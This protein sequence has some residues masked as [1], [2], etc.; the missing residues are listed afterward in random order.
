VTQTLCQ[1][2]DQTDNIIAMG[3][4][5]KTF[6]CILLVLAV[7]IVYGRACGFGFIDCDD[8]NYVGYVSAQPAGF[9][10]DNLRWAA[11]TFTFS[12]WH[13]LTWISYLLDRSWFNDNPGIMHAENI[14]LHAANSALLFLVLE[15][16]T[17]KSWRSAMV[18]ALFA[19]H[20]MHVESVVWIAERKDVLSMFFLLMSWLIYVEY[21]RRPSVL[22][23]L[24]LTTSFALSLASKAMGVTFPILLLL[25]DVWPLGRL[26][27]RS[28]KEWSRAIL[29]KVPLLLLSLIVSILTVLA[30]RAGRSLSTL[31]SIP[32]GPRLANAALGCAVYVAKLIV[33]VDL[34]VFYPM[35]F[36]FPPMA[37]GSAILLLALITAG[38]MRIGK[39]KSYLVIGWFWFLVSLLPMI[40]LVQV[41]QQ[42]IADRYSYLPSIGIS[43]A[44][45]WGL[46]DLFGTGALGKGILTAAGAGVL[47]V[48][49]LLTWRQVGYWTDAQTLFSH[50][51]AVTDQ[52]WFAYCH[53]GNAFAK[54]GDYSAATEEYL[55]TIEFNPNYA[56]AYCN[57]GNCIYMV[58]PARAIP[59][60]LKTIELEPEDSKG[61]I[62]LANA[63]YALGRMND[64]AD[65]YRK[66]L[67]R[68]PGS[69][70]A[71]DGLEK[72][73]RAAGM[74]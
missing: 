41:G 73:R 74:E 48:F 37:V 43:I 57:L 60:Y 4:W 14:L 44:I 19:L 3:V 69:A 13:P 11:T 29:E 23:Y 17:G 42:S 25:W 45:V 55:K 63:Y 24:I 18:A 40:G 49:A 28:G 66:G 61:Y 51:A 72:A 2:L 10:W 36:T 27:W 15:R 62:D 32:L 26:T 65:D 16:S 5:R 12:N 64:A 70:A 46:S 53:L 9:T 22:K 71:R 34:A 68:D 35:R 67:E 21:T 50:T 33:P 20:A 59:L 6:I 39:T 54:R 38:A 52:N 8:S 47:G 56:E 7:W 58:D 1:N 30:Q 31:D